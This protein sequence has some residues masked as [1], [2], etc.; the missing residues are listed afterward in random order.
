MTVAQ[1]TPDPADPTPPTKAAVRRQLAIAALLSSPSIKV[2]AGVLG[3]SESSL[4]RLLRRPEFK[5]AYETAARSVTQAAVGQLQG[6]TLEAVGVLRNALA[7]DMTADRIRAATV[8]LD[9]AFQ[10]VELAEV[11]AKLREVEQMLVEARRGR[12]ERR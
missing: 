8:I 5:A 2:A 7:A 12:T 6:A 3:C 4:Y 11:Q 1:P 10:A 9:R